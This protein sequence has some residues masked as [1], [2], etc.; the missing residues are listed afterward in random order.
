M[1]NEISELIRSRRKELGLTQADLS[2]LTGVSTRSIFEL[3]NGNNSMTFK[4]VLTILEA[5]GLGMDIKVA[6][7][8]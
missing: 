5:L 4:R 8:G 2:D 3:E 1:P 7:N 6:K